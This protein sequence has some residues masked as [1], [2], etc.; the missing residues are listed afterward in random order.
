MP[1]ETIFNNVD[2]C[3]LARSANGVCSDLNKDTGW[4]RAITIPLNLFIIHI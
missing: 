4:L 1:Q 3:K 2:L